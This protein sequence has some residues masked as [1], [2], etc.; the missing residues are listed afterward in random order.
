MDWGLNDPK[1]PKEYMF[2]REEIIYPAKYY[3]IA[4]VQDFVFRFGWTLSV[5]LTEV[6]A[7]PPD[8]ITL[9]L[10]PCEIFR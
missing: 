8:L 1:A 10:A 3:Y 7:I 5:S 9:V 2:L 6:G 4:M